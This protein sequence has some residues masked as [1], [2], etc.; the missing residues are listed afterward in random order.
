MSVSISSP[1]MRTERLTT[2]PPRLMTATSVVPPPMSTIRLPDG[3]LTGQAGADGG[4]HRLLDEPRPARAGVDRRIAH[5]ALL[6]LGHARRDA[7]QDPRA[8]DASVSVVH[9]VDEVADHLLGDVE[10]ADDAVAQRPD[11]DDVRRRAADHPLRLGADGEDALRAGVHGHDARLADDDPAIPDGDE[12]VG[13]AEVDPDVVTEEAEQAVE[14]S[15]LASGMTIRVRRTRG[16]I[17]GGAG[18]MRLRAGNGRAAVAGRALPYHG[19]ATGPEIRRR[20]ARHTRW[21]MP[22]RDGGQ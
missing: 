22:R 10:V 1:P 5:G 9:L 8:R 18:M 21:R 17:G 11:G 6:D 14:E 15:Q 3:S 7:D 19:N 13:R 20:V 4:R 2:I 16:T 12:R